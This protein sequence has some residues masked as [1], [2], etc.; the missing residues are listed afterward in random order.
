LRA[1]RR[2]DRNIDALTASKFSG[3]LTGRGTP[4]LRFV[5]LAVCLNVVTH[6][7]IDFRSRTGANGAKL[8]RFRNARCGLITEHPLE[9]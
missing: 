6:V 1:E 8:K 4:V 3:D 2:G 9:K 5:A 7:T